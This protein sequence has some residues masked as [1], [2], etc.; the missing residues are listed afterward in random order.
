MKKVAA[1]L[2]LVTLPQD[3]ADLSQ[4]VIWGELDLVE[5]SSRVA[6]GLIVALKAAVLIGMF[7]MHTRVRFKLQFF[8]FEDAPDAELAYGGSP[9]VGSHAHPCPSCR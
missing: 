9:A 5:R 1:L 8:E 6:I 7:L 2:T 3:A 4:V